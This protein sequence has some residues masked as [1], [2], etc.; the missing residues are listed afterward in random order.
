MNV[1]FDLSIILYRN[2]YELLYR[3][4]G[5]M[6]GTNP[7]HI[8]EFAKAV[9]TSIWSDLNMMPFA[10]R[11]ILAK[12]SRSWRKDFYPEYKSGRKKKKGKKKQFN[13]QQFNTAVEMLVSDLR[14]FGI[15]TVEADGLE[16]DDICWFWSSIFFK[17]K[18]KTV[19]ITRD[20]DLH[21]M[22][23]YDDDGH[24]VVVFDDLYKEKKFYV[25]PGMIQPIPEKEEISIFDMPVEDEHDYIRENYEEVD[26]IRLV[27]TK[28]LAGDNGDDVPGCQIGKYKCSTKKATMIYDI[29]ADRIES[30]GWG[31]YMDSLYTDDSVASDLGVLI[32]DKTPGG[33][34]GA[35][36][37]F[38]ADLRRNMKLIR[39]SKLTYDGLLTA[40]LKS[41]LPQVS[42][43]AQKLW[44][45]NRA[46][47]MDRT[48][49][50][51]TKY[52]HKVYYKPL[53]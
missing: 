40:A 35:V 19:I 45:N 31:D 50:E 38:V 15:I 7:D 41:T 46:A 5:F 13:W 18:E 3:Q 52:D 20:S 28:I 11:V 37:Q 43:Q 33:N 22:L 1:I 6:D 23:K 39:L 24:F 17:R 21:Q 51:N 26:P 4:P 27:F 29:L 30:A 42:S 44:L 53:H 25:T 9:Y 49:V 2:L 14:S 12:D 10:S 47:F 8:D 36:P 32:M 16:A 34:F 48:L